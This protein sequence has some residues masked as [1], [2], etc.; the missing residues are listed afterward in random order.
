MQIYNL[1][2]PNGALKGTFLTYDEAKIESTKIEL[3]Y[4]ETAELNGLTH[5]DVM[6][7]GLNFFNLHCSIHS[8]DDKQLIIQDG[9][10]RFIC[11][12]DLIPELEQPDEY[13]DPSSRSVFSVE[14]LRINNKNIYRLN[15][16]DDLI[17][18][19]EHQA[20]NVIDILNENLER[21]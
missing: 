21:C 9:N 12:V 19:I 15:L 14:T 5:Q 16:S 1:K 4:V 7:G 8:K 2:F 6:Q 13:S 20:S 3:S 17:R 18:E 11:N 10:G